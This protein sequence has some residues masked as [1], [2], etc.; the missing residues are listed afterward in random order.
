MCVLVG[1][2]GGRGCMEAQGTHI[3]ISSQ[4]H[5]MKIVKDTHKHSTNKIVLGSGLV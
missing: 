5:V 3:E 4:S 1:L 2:G